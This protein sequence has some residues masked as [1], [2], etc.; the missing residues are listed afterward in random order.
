MGRVRPHKEDEQEKSI[1]KAIK[2]LKSG[3]KMSIRAVA[4]SFVVPKTTLVYRYKGERQA[5]QQ[6]S[7]HK[8]LLTPAEERAIVQWA[9][10]L[11]DWGFT[12]RLD[13]VKDM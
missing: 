13:L 11:D 3:T 8:Q 9:Q 7:E 1:Q 4:E 10:K 2:A 6:A 5:R 12:P